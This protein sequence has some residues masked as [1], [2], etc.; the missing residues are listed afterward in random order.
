MTKKR[1]TARRLTAKERDGV[2]AHLQLVAQE[3][4]TMGRL[5]STGGEKLN[6]AAEFERV[7]EM[8]ERYLAS[9]LPKAGRGR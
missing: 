5:Y 3:A 6:P 8:C 1:S 7:N 9:R 2:L 4:H